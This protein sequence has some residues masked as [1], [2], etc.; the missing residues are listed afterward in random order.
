[1]TLVVALVLPLALAQ[2]P[3]PAPAPPTPPASAQ[4]VELT[5][6]WYAAHRPELLGASCAA[7]TGMTARRVVEEGDDWS[8]TSTLA[9]TAN[10]GDSAVSVPYTVS[11]RG[12]HVI[13]TQ[14]VEQLVGQ[15]LVGT[16]LVLVGRSMDL[17]GDTLVVLTSYRVQ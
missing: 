13:A 9:A 3:A 2:D 15:G 17:D 6:A 7:S 8:A 1:M 16:R 5:T 14:L 4:S 12:E 11:A 10:N